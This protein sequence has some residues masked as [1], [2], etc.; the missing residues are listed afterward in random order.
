MADR[1]KAAYDMP[2]PNAG[3]PGRGG[4]ADLYRDAKQWA[5]RS[6][7]PSDTWLDPALLEKALDADPKLRK[8]LA[9]T[10]DELG[11]PPPRDAPAKARVRERDLA[12]LLSRLEQHV[13][14]VFAEVVL[15]DIARRFHQVKRFVAMYALAKESARRRSPNRFPALEEEDE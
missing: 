13:E 4:L 2:P 10:L 3:L 8:A 5:F 7:N 14:R 9:A 11:P 15:V 6:A 1:T 12:R